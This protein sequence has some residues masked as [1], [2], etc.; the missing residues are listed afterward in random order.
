[1]L[2]PQIAQLYVNGWQMGKRIANL[3]PQVSFPVH[4]GILNYHGQ[5]TV[6]IS[7]W[8]LG[9]QPQDLKIPS[10][11][12]VQLGVYSGGVGGVV[13]NNPGWSELR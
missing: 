8:A 6:S 13:V 9:D 3:G 12:L 1:M 11:Q 7:L 5:N 10:F 2:T 4:E